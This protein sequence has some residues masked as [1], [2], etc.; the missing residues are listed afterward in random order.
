MGAVV[1][2]AGIAWLA[3]RRHATAVHFTALMLKP[4]VPGI[5]FSS[6]CTMKKG[7]WCVCV[8]ACVCVCVCVC[9]FVC[10]R[11]QT[12]TYEHTHTHTHARGCRIKSHMYVCRY[13]CTY[14][15]IK[16]LTKHA[17]S[18]DLDTKRRMCYLR[19]CAPPA[20]CPMYKG[21]QLNATVPQEHQRKARSYHIRSLRNVFEGLVRWAAASSK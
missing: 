6:W 13:V 11:L 9:V 16:H 20:S 2:L 5:L 1:V 21:V 10:V 18:S 7:V 4:V 14:V 19:I 3:F 17:A 15:C 8:C 12:H